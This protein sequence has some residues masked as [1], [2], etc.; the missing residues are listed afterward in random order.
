VER[1]AEKRFA[2]NYQSGSNFRVFVNSV[3][4]Y[5]GVLY[6]TLNP[7][8]SG[9]AAL[10]FWT[11]IFELQRRDSSFG[12]DSERA[13][14]VLER[15]MK[16]LRG[17]RS[18]V[19]FGGV[20]M[21]VDSSLQLPRRRRF[22]RFKEPDDARVRTKGSQDII[23]HEHEIV[24]WCLGK[25]AIGFRKKVADRVGGPNPDHRRHGLHSPQSGET[26]RKSSQT[27][28]PGLRLPGEQGPQ[29]VAYGGCEK[30]R[31]AGIHCRFQSYR[32]AR[33]HWN[34]LIPANPCQSV[35]PAARSADEFRSL[36]G[37]FRPVRSTHR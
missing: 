16:C 20:Q 6:P 15:L 8:K 19:G 10:I 17:V 37:P 28:K 26:Q 14:E 3:A 11:P 13:P 21:A 9:S 7:G 33:I 35:R 5:N 25:R 2:N 22:F 36:R 1:F 31:R 29:C 34:A 30:H 24:R 23:E 12:S 27:A 4:R 18:R 32:G